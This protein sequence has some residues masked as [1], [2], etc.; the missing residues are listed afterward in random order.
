[1][2]TAKTDQTGGRQD[3]PRELAIFEILGSISQPMSHK[4]AS[5]IPRLYHKIYS[6][7]LEFNLRYLRAQCQNVVKFPWGVIFCSSNP[8]GIPTPMSENI[9]RCVLLTRYLLFL[10]IFPL[11]SRCCN[12]EY[13]NLL[14]KNDS[15]MS[16]LK[17]TVHPSEDSDQHGHL[18]RL[19]R[20][21]AEHSMGS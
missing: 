13:V 14:P 7:L 12:K 4:C 5:K 20:A 15:H 9:D 17:M 16:R 21:F 8:Q 10:P 2:Q 11:D 18:P 19:I 6:F 3:Y 1:M